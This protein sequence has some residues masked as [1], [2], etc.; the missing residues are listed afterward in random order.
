VPQVVSR[1]RAGLEKIGHEG[2]PAD[3][4]EK[5]KAKLVV[6]DAMRNTTPAQRAFQ[7]SIDELYGLGYDYEKSF[8]ERIGK[9]KVDDVVAVV[10]KYFSHAV[11]TTSSPEPAPTLK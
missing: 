8:P 9:V 10:K 2:I 11:V 7:A 3:E 6:A 5:A 4:F 1:I